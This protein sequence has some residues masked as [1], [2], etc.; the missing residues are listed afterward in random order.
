MKCPECLQRLEISDSGSRCENGHTFG[1]KNGVHQIIKTEF[2]SK[3]MPFLEGFED[4]RKEEIAKYSPEILRKL[5]F[6]DFDKA[7]WSLRQMDLELIE[8]YI[9]T[10]R[11]VLELGAWNSWLT[12]HLVKGGMLATVV[13]LFIHELDGLGAKQHYSEDWLAIQMDLQA[14]EIIDDQFDLIVVNRAMPYFRDLSRTLD[15]LKFLLK[16]GGTL[17]VTGI[18]YQKNTQRI[19]KQLDAASRAFETVYETPFM[20]HE[21]KGFFAQEDLEL[22]NSKGLQLQLYPKLRLRS[23]AASIFSSRPAY[24]YGIFEKEAWAN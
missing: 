9:Q 1:M 10:N 2:Q 7:M 11:T 16:E 6:V 15:I 23:Y 8:K 3:L 21:F 14:L 18:T 4:F 19:Q 20:L 24:Y 13:D 17:I 22:M 5:P 12:Q